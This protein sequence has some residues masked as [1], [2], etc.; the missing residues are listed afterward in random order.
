LAFVDFASDGG[1]VGVL[2][3]GNVEFASVCALE[4]GSGIESAG[5]HSL[6]IEPVEELP[7]HHQMSSRSPSRCFAPPPN[8]T[9]SLHTFP[10]PPSSASSLG[11]GS[12]WFLAR[13]QCFS[14]GHCM[15]WVAALKNNQI[16]VYIFF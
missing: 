2:Q 1:F 11:P 6:K 7:S 10:P 16:I 14:S 4:L 13:T 3:V 8:P 5:L 15:F 12:R 9:R